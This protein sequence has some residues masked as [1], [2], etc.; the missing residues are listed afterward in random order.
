MNLSHID[1]YEQLVDYLREFVNW[2]GEVAPYDAVGV[3]HLLGA[4]LDNLHRHGIEADF[5]EMQERLTSDQEAVLRR[6]AV[7]LK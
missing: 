6:I 1:S 5:V 3:T 2:Q 7:H 4:L